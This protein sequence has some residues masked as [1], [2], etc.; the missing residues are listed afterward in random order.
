[1]FTRSDKISVIIS[2]IGNAHPDDITCLAVDAYLVY[3]GCQN[4][5]RAFASG[6]Q[7]GHPDDI[8]CL[9]VDA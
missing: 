1:M 3:T 5:I 9:A 8:T 2:F 7:V 4:V 6:R